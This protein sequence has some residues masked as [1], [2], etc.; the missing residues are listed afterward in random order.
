MSE[1]TEERL[2]GFK[3]AIDA[4][5]KSPESLALNFYELTPVN[6]LLF[7][8]TP[9]PYDIKLTKISYNFGCLDLSSNGYIQV[10]IS[11]V[12]NPNIYGTLEQNSNIVFS[13]MGG[14]GQ[15]VEG[16]SH[17]FDNIVLG[18]NEPTFVYLI[19]NIPS[20]VGV[21]GRLAL[22]YSPLWK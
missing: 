9:T 1:P 7:T 5:E 11:K 20:A 14:A 10:V 4:I 3:Q 19:S 16:D 15:F 6:K 12:L 17:F 18:K 21:I 2:E 13:K 8:L 22:Y